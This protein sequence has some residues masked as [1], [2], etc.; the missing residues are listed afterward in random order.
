MAR[1]VTHSKSTQ[2]DGQ[3]VC[4]HSI[5]SLPTI[6]EYNIQVDPTFSYSNPLQMLRTKPLDAK[7]N[8]RLQMSELAKAAVDYEYDMNHPYRHV[9]SYKMDCFLAYGIPLALLACKCTM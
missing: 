2:E 9:V 8:A 7:E 3:I 5:F 6:G 4:S 1:F